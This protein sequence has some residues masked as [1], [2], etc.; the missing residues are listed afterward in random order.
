VGQGGAPVS[1][2]NFSGFGATRPLAGASGDMAGL[3]TTT[4]GGAVVAT[5]HYGA[6]RPRRRNGLAAMGCWWDAD[7]HVRDM[8][9]VAVRVSPECR[10]RGRRSRWRFGL[11]V[12][13]RTTARVSQRVLTAPRS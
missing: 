8:L 11:L 13:G 1:P 6:R 5:R 3:C 4:G 2:L 7:R 10:G 12:R 9:G